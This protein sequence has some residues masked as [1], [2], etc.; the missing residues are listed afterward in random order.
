MMDC[1]IDR[2]FNDVSMNAIGV[3]VV[4]VDEILTIKSYEAELVEDI[5]SLMASF[6]S[7]I[8]GRRS[9]QNRKK[10]EQSE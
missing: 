6:S 7:K 9:S 2:Q 4:I 8:Y 5:L 10:K 3:Q 1:I